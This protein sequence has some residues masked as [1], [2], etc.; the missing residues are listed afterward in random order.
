MS[1]VTLLTDFG[2]RDPY[3]GVMQGVIAGSAPEVRLI[4]L[5]HAVPAQDVIIGGWQLSRAWRHFPPGSIHLAVVD[6]GVGSARRVLL[7]RCAGHYFVAPDNGL[8]A[9]AWQGEEPDLVVAAERQD[10]YRQPLSSTFHGR[11]VFA[12]L[13][14]WLAAGGDIK[15]AGPV[16]RDWQR[17][18][19]P[20]PEAIEGGWLGSVLCADH[21]GNI[22]TTLPAQLIAL[23]AAVAV[24]KYAIPVCDHYAAVASGERL[25]LAGSDGWIEISVRDG[26]A[27]TALAVHR[28]EPVR[29]LLN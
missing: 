12:P 10:L 15:D 8:L 22:I 11:D 3:V 5:T 23:P 28:G 16:V 2:M 17:A 27:W 26:N 29:L 18:V 1:I 19:L 24:G 14:G 21:F 4:D 13:A 6:P 20:E 7:A 9:V 25:A